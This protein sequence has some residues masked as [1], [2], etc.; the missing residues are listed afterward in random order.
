[1]ELRGGQLQLQSNQPP[2][3]HEHHHTGGTSYYIPGEHCLCLVI[4]VAF[5]DASTTP[6]RCAADEYCWHRSVKRP[7]AID[8]HTVAAPR[9]R[10]FDRALRIYVQME[11]RYS[12]FGKLL[13][14]DW[15]RLSVRSGVI[16]RCRCDINRNV[17]RR[18]LYATVAV[19]T[20]L[21]Q[22]GVI[23]ADDRHIL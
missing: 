11:Y 23:R 5:D 2:T 19:F 20:R 4:V 7:H 22:L 14:L 6:L 1:M 9:P 21:E 12:L 15:I 17:S 3:P 16:E 13:R 8:D 10:L 18:R